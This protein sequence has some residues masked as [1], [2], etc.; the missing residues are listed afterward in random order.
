MRSAFPISETSELRDLTHVIFVSIGENLVYLK[1]QY[2]NLFWVHDEI[3]A[4]KIK[5]SLNSFT[6][7]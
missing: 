7:K 2:D 1:I 5:G 4:Q 6:A 3:E